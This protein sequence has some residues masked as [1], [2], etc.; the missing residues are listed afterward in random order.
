MTTR[1]HAVTGSIRRPIRFFVTGGQVADDIG[2]RALCGSLPAVER[3][4][5]DR[6]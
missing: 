3:L 4:D 2:A 1:L 5:A 6:G